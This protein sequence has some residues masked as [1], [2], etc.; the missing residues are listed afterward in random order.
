MDVTFLSV[1][2]ISRKQVRLQV[3]AW[4]ARRLGQISVPSVRCLASG[5]PKSTWRERCQRRGQL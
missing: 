5:I 2:R 1:A 4:A 3:F